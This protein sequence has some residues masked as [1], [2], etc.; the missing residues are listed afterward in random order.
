MAAK[1]WY[2]TD[3]SV[4]VGSD[5]SATDPGAEAFRSPVT[6]W[7][8]GTGATDHSEWFNDVERAASTF[9]GTT[10]PDGSLDT[11]NGDF[12]T[13][14][15]H[16]LSGT[17]AS[18]NWNI[19]LG[20]RA[21]T[22]GGAQDGRGRFRLFK[23]PNQNGSGATEITAAQQ[24]GGLVTNLL[25]SA[26]QVSIAT[27][28]PGSF[29]VAD[30]EYVF[31]QLAWER[32]GA[33][34]M[35]THDVN[36]RIGGSSGCHVV[37]SDFAVV[38]TLNQSTETDT[39]QPVGK[40]KTAALSQ[41]TE[42]DL[43]QAFTVY[44]SR[45]IALNQATETDT[46]QAIAWAPKR[47]LVG[48]SMETDLSQAF[49]RLKTL[50]VGQ[51]TETDLTQTFGKVKTVALGLTTETDLAQAFSSSQIVALAQAVETDLSQAFGKS[52][53]AALGLTTETGLAQAFGKAKVAA[54]GQS[55]ETDLAQS[56]VSVKT[57]AIGLTT[58]TDLAQI[59]TVVSGGDIV[60][61]NQATEIDFAQAIATVKAKG[62]SFVV[63][64]DTAQAITA[65]KTKALGQ[66]TE[67]DLAQTMT[68]LHA[69]TITMGQAVETDRA[70]PF[71]RFGVPPT[72]SKFEYDITT[73]VWTFQVNNRIRMSL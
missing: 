30:N 24:N 1:T 53:S 62:V 39:S 35:T 47:R 37:T 3:N 67:I 10:V 7:I 17:Y 13:S 18:G 71:T 34:G 51:T 68:W 69:Y 28:N 33:A 20:V 48:Q 54:L 19:H 50:A 45:I 16:A 42:T 59:L 22:G 57:K 65:S 55:T 11:T 23:G 31:V 6:G 5:L 15:I 12:W 25:T 52:K 56:F 70:R 64:T 61:L 2:L 60:A 49:G 44:V 73:G 32:T 14:P 43:A 8:V 21:N 9:T 38:G 27:F 40:L 29:T 36:A 58:E 4:S 41:S 66:V 26:T 63:E 72:T 46:S